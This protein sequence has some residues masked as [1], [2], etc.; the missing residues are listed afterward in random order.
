MPVS[1]TSIGRLA[2]REFIHGGHDLGSPHGG[3]VIFSIHSVSEIAESRDIRDYYW[4]AEDPYSAS[5]PR[6]MSEEAR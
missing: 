5:A 6:E 2:I 3:T 4:L 1:I